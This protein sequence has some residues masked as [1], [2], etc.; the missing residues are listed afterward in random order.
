MGR[1]DGTVAVEVRDHGTGLDDDAAQRAFERF[2]RAD[3]SRSRAS[4]GTGLGLAIVA[5]IVARHGGSV[6]HR[7]TPGGGATFRVEL[8][9]AA[10]D[11]ADVPEPVDEVSTGS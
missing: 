7:P 10:P 2:Y 6:R 1:V 11:G 8:P 4:G 3:R 5:A 9:A